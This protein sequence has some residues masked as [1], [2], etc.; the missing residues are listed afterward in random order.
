L[1][2]PYFWAEIQ[3]KTGY[4]LI[5]PINH[6][7]GYWQINEDIVIIIYNSTISTKI[8]GHEC[9]W[10]KT[11]NALYKFFITVKK[12]YTFN[13]S[14]I[15]SNW[16]FKKYNFK[17]VYMSFLCSMRQITYEDIK[18]EMHWNIKLHKGTLD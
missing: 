18:L 14:W 8:L 17:K 6:S 2:A 9:H 13:F 1:E 5:R 4:T 7:A 10:P 11:K 12:I 15:N 3:S 16:K